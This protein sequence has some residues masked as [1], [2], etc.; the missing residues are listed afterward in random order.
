VLKNPDGRTA[1][2][3]EEKEALIREILFSPALVAEIERMISLE[4]AHQQ[5]TEQRV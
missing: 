5:I 2:T 3:I 1:T 4:R